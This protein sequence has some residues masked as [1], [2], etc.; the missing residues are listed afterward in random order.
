[1]E[2]VKSVNN[3]KMVNGEQLME[4]Q[5]KPIDFSLQVIPDNPEERLAFYDKLFYKAYK[6]N[7]KLEIWDISIGM[8]S[9]V[10]G[11]YCLMCKIKE[12]KMDE[13]GE[14]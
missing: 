12:K 3:E 11:D 13:N 9:S 1:M 4:F 8:C 10:E 14:R 5:L 6:K 2:N 7:L